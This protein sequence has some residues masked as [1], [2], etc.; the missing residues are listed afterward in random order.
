MSHVS[1]RRQTTLTPGEIARRLRMGG[2]KSWN[3]ALYLR[4]RA[5]AKESTE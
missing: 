2:W 1:L 5:T 3:K 4:N